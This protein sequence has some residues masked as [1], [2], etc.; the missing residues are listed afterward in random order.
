MFFVNSA[1]SRV[2]NLTSISSA[3]ASG[4]K[5][6]T[7]PNIAKYRSL[8]LSMVVLVLMVLVVLVTRF[9]GV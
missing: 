3:H 7:L 4:Q 9:D 1:E 6:A 8:E 5:A 2:D